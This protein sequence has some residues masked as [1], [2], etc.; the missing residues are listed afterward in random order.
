MW[1]KKKDH[2]TAPENVP[3]GQQQM[4]KYLFLKIQEEKH[5]SVVFEPRLF[6]P[7]CSQLSE[8]DV[9]FQTCAAKNKGLSHFSPKLK[10]FLPESNR[11]SSFLMLPQLPIAEISDESSCEV[12]LASA[13]PPLMEGRPT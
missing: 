7:P 3:K 2:F 4:K 1:K 12:G 8:A 11:T 13:K 6:P 10:G 9:P 5:E